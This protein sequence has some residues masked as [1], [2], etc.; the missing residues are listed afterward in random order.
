MTKLREPLTYERTL[1]NVAALI[2]WDRC[3][4]ICGV[5][6]VEAVR[7]W[8]DPDCETQIRMIDAERLDRA[9]VDHG[10]D[11]RPFYRL[12]GLRADIADRDPPDHNLAAL[13][14][15]A[16]KESG[17]AIAAMIEAS[18][19]KDVRVRRRARQEIHEAV[20]T[21]KTGLAALDRQEKGNVQ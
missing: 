15:Q 1:T 3:A 8:G 6:S 7:L 20:D 13:A 4:A 14:G 10:G 12:Y 11:H 5:R 16:A 21:L 2:G 18:N 9:Y 19:S 17:E